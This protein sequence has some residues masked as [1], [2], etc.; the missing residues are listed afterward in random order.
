MKNVALV[1]SLLILLAASL[2]VL[3]MLFNFDSFVKPGRDRAQSLSISFR[4]NDTIKAHSSLSAEQTVFKAGL[5]SRIKAFAA[6]T[7]EGRALTVGIVIFELLALVAAI[8]VVAIKL[9]QLPMTDSQV[10]DSETVE[11]DSEIA[12]PD[13]N[14][15][16][17]EDKT[18]GDVG[19]ETGEIV[20]VSL[21]S[22]LLIIITIALVASCSTGNV[23]RQKNQ[24]TTGWDIIATVKAAPYTFVYCVEEENQD[25]RRLY[26]SCPKDHEFS[27]IEANND[28]DL[29]P[30]FQNGTQSNDEND[31]FCTFYHL[32]ANRLSRT[33]NF[34]ITLKYGNEVK[35]VTV[36][37]PST[38]NDAYHFKD[39]AFT[40]WTF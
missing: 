21:G 8:V 1:V 34:G 33:M 32:K 5:V 7:P 36:D 35:L 37:F 39:A 22:V 25:S 17:K 12:N 19:W 2:S 6:A 26:I 14:L 38:K 27:Q 18:S 31:V 20:G 30:F 3:L 16:Q 11:D 4:K 28:C 23:R 24:H 9:N 15:I 40:C 10:H 13:Q 29:N